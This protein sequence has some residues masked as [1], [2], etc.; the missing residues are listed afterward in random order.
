MAQGEL[1]RTRQN[2][3]WCPYHLL[4]RCD[5]RIREFERSLP[6]RRML[7]PRRALRGSG[8]VLLCDELPL[9][10]LPPHHRRCLRRSPASS[11]ASSA[12]SEART[13]SPST[14]TKPPTTPTAPAAARCFIPGCATENGST[15]PWEPWSMPPRS[16]RAPTFSW[17][18]RRPGTR[19][20]IICRNIGATSGMSEGTCC[21]PVWRRTAAGL[22]RR[23]RGPFGLPPAPSS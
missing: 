14:V 17:G 23:T 12:S 16:D 10:E 2:A 11:R 21:A 13:S 8:R 18:R 6:D 3:L 19:L 9:L 1:S 20:R 7:L 4:G 5:D 15:S 22:A